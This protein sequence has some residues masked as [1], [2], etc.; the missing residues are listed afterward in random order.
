MNVTY[1][2]PSCG[3]GGDQE[4]VLWRGVMYYVG[5]GSAGVLGALRKESGALPGGGGICVDPLHQA[6]IEQVDRSSVLA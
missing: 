6:V 3:G 5:E 1:P 4:N 2:L